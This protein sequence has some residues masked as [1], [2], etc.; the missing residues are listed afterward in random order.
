MKLRDLIK[1]LGIDEVARRL[2]RS[3]STVRKW[4]GKPPRS[5]QAEVTKVIRRSEG[6]RRG[7][8]KKK[9]KLPRSKAIREDRKRIRELEKKLEKMTL[10]QMPYWDRIQLEITLHAGGLVPYRTLKQIAR[11]YG[12]P[13]RQV[14]RDYVSPKLSGRK[15]A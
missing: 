11:M 14:Y 5:A 3:P 15:A 10:E 13:L 8:R 4:K 9:S 7:A 6:A 1:R 2:H 12:I